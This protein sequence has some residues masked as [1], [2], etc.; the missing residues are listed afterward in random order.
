MFEAYFRLF[1]TLEICWEKQLGGYY[2]CVKAYL[3]ILATGDKLSKSPKACMLLAKMN[4]L[5]CVW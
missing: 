4:R 5:E 3:W 1:N 2:F